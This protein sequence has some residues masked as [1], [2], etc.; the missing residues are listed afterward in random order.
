MRRLIIGTLLAFMALPAW[1]TST[2]APHYFDGCETMTFRNGQLPTVGYDGI[3][4]YGMDPNASKLTDTIGDMSSAADSTITLGDLH[5]DDEF[6]RAVFKVDLSALPDDAI[7]VEATAYLLCTARNMTVSQSTPVCLHRLFRPFDDQ[8]SWT[9]RVAVGTDTAWYDGGAV[10]GPGLV[11]KW[12]AYGNATYAVLS[13]SNDYRTSSAGV[14]TFA[15]YPIAC[16]SDSIGTGYTQVAGQEKDALGDP[17]V[18]EF[19]RWHL[20]AST[21]W[22]RFDITDM[23]RRWHARQWVADG[24]ALELDLY[25]DAF[26]VTFRGC[27]PATTG[28][29]LLA[30]RKPFVVVK[31]L[32]CVWPE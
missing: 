1:G 23:A 2:T 17:D 25:T 31:Y 12:D 8:V 9:N 7:I 21:V 10:S 28:T 27:F 24:F 16:G 32:H 19:G 5:G 20:A 13:P 3:R 15:T 11:A 26:Y 6:H 18:L 22:T 29:G 30:K 4:F 14:P